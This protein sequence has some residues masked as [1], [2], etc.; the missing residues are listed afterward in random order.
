MCCRNNCKLCDKLTITQAVT[1][2]A[3]TTTV[4]ATLSF[5]LPE[6]SYRNREKYCI[7][8]AQPIPDEATINAEVV[9]TVGDGTVAYPL[10]DANCR[11][12]LAGSIRTRMKYAT[13]VA[14]NITGGNFKLLENICCA[15]NDETDALE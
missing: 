9:F 1:F 4:P 14:T 2:T 5:E 3:A 10:L 7:I 13:R 6:G 15:I 11:Q 12:V 8:I